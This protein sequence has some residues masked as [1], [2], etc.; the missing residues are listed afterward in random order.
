[1][2]EPDDYGIQ[3]MGYANQIIRVGDPDDGRGRGALDLNSEGMGSKGGG[4]G[5]GLRTLLKILLDYSCPSA[6]LFLAN[7]TKV[8]AGF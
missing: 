3:L 7:H 4:M 1:M 2:M 5:F 8:K 6:V